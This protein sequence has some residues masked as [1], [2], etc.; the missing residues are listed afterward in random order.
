MSI[1][2]VLADNE[3]ELMQSR[4]C[5]NGNKVYAI[6]TTQHNSYTLDYMLI[7]VPKDFDLSQDTMYSY[8]TDITDLFYFY[9][10]IS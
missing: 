10:L 2:S 5:K 1:E 7:V 6:D 8:F 9:D 4:E 3:L